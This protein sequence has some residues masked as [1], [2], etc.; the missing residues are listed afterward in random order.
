L[1]IQIYE[2][3][4]GGLEIRIFGR[5]ID[6]CPNEDT[7]RGV[8]GRT[9]GNDWYHPENLFALTL[10]CR[11]TYAE[12]SPI[13]FASNEIDGSINHLYRAVH[14][15]AL[16][17]RLKIVRI[18]VNENEIDCSCYECD[19]KECWVRGMYGRFELFLD[20]LVTGPRLKY[21]VIEWAGNHPV[22]ANSF[23]EAIGYMVMSCFTHY[24]NDLACIEIE[25][26]HHPGRKAWGRRRD[27]Y[28]D[29]I[30]GELL[31]A[32]RFM[33]SDNFLMRSEGDYGTRTLVSTIKFLRHSNGTP[34]T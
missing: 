14:S 19:D 27:E 34:S 6:D 28:R 16:C 1:R 12:A 17:S 33:M 3:A 13:F 32:I 10:V 4:L 29:Y 25:Y 30:D 9:Q 8:I 21:V 24:R 5:N 22:W 31:E 11:Q 23:H 7:L 20:V 18:L 2:Y 26:L 15:E